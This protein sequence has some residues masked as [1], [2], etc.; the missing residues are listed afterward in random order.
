MLFSILRLFITYYILLSTKTK[1]TI[2]RFKGSNMAENNIAF[3]TKQ[4]KIVKRSGETVNFDAN[5]IYDAITK[6]VAATNE[7]TP[8][9][10]LTITQF[11]LNKLDVEFA[12]CPP[13]V[14]QVQDTVIDPS[15]FLYGYSYKFPDKTKE[16][17]KQDGRFISFYSSFWLEPFSLCI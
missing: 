7:M 10:V 12:D 16:F 1:N 8:S 4:T 14:E 15:D 11:V 5:K 3:I 2:Y 6:A 9:Q 17:G 13:T